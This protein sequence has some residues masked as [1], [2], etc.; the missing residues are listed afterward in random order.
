MDAPA[1][2]EARIPDLETIE[3]RRDPRFSANETARTQLHM[4]TN[5]LTLWRTRDFGADLARLRTEA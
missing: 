2:I 3:S 5:V 1:L 4:M